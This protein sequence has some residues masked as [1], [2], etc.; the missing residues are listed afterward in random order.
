[1][2]TI[3]GF[4]TFFRR[5]LLYHGLVDK[6]KAASL[7]GV[8]PYFIR[9]YEQASLKF[10]LKQASNA[11]SLALEADLKSKGVGVKSLKQHDILQELL[12][13]YLLY[14]IRAMGIYWDHLHSKF[15]IRTRKYHLMR[16]LKNSHRPLH[17]LFDVL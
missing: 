6:S 9:D 10:S 17:R 4:Y 7:L 15:H 13:R 12:V 8:N 5:V 1:M 14:K 3:S 11:I 2:L 16:V